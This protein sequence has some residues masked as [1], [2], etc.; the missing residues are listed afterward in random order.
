[1]VLQPEIVFAQPNFL[2]AINL[3][4]T[5]SGLEP[6]EI[7]MALEIDPGQWTRIRAGDSHFP[8]NKLKELME[9]CGNEAPLI[10][11]ANACGKGLVL[12]KTEAERLYEE[13]QRE[14]HEER[15]KTRLLTEL[16]QGKR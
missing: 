2:A 4:I 9:I 11:L 3:C 8:P 5:A 6:K 13:S 12:L 1:M 10:W 7:H 15:Q 14:L 16:F